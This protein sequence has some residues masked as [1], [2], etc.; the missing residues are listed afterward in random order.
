MKL[1]ASSARE[2]CQGAV[3]DAGVAVDEEHAGG[4][5]VVGHPVAGEF[6]APTGGALHVVADP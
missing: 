2:F 3:I 1:R 4:L 6:A 5:D